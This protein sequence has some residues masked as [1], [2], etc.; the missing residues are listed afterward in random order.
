[1]N[2]IKTARIDRIFLFMA[3]MTITCPLFA[4]CLPGGGQG[5]S[6]YTQASWYSNLETQNRRCADNAYHNLSKELVCASWDFPLHTRLK[7]KCS[8]REVILQV[9]DRGPAKRLYKVGRRIDLSQR[10]FSILSGGR[11]DRGVIKVEV[12]VATADRFR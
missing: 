2:K 11:L 3:L 5:H 7:V 1:M 8:S 10:A 9:C 12:S 4:E 6:F